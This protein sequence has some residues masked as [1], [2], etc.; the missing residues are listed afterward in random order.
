MLPIVAGIKAA[1]Q[2]GN[3]W[4]DRPRS[5]A[6]MRL[7]LLSTGNCADIKTVPGD[8]LRH[9]SFENG[10]LHGHRRWRGCFGRELVA[11]AAGA[12]PAVKIGTT[13]IIG[14]HEADPTRIGDR[15]VH[16]GGVLA[17][18]ADIGAAERIG[19]YSRI[20]SEE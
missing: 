4:I 6:P 7:A 10:R 9:G 12:I 19:K 3:T 13:A 18:R 20:R 11:D 8:G 5:V 1:E 2:A 14:T 15:G 16:A 17:I